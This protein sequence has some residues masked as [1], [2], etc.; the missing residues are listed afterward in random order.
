ME[1]TLMKKTNENF[2]NS[3]LSKWHTFEE[4]FSKNDCTTLIG[5][6]EVLEKMTFEV[7]DSSKIKD[8]RKVYDS[9]ISMQ[10]ETPEVDYARYENIKTYFKVFENKLAQAGPSLITLHKT[11]HKD[12]KEDTRQSQPPSIPIL[13]IRKIANSANFATNHSRTIYTIVKLPDKKICTGGDDGIIKMFDLSNFECIVSFQAHQSGIRSMVLL[14]NQQIATGSYDKTIKLW[15]SPADILNQSQVTTKSIKN[16]YSP[17]K[18]LTGHTSCVIALKFIA[19]GNLLASGSADYT[20]KI[21]ELEK[22]EVI[23]NFTGHM[24]DILC[25]ACSTNGMTL[26]S[27]SADRTI[28]LWS[29][30]KKY[31]SACLKTLTGIN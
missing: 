9:L 31:S 28:K 20:I 15:N 17:L 30:G 22:G 25:F 10:D 4:I 19:N 24:N 7:G 14:P 18:T 21:W 1:E 16:A 29:L 8:I 6:R 5:L 13:S 11:E 2:E 27:G 23:K 3:Y 26:V 12:E